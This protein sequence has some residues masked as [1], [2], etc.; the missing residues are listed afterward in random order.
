MIKTMKNIYVKLVNNEYK[1]ITDSDRQELTDCLMFSFLKSLKE[2]PIKE[3]PQDG[4]KVFTSEWISD[5]TI[6]FGTKNY[7]VFIYDVRKDKISLFKDHKDY[8]VKSILEENIKADDINFTGIKSIKRNNYLNFTSYSAHKD[9]YIYKGLMEYNHLYNAHENW[10][11]NLEWTDNKLISSSSDNTL[12]VWGSDNSLRLNLKTENDYVRNFKIKGDNLY[13]MYK[14]GRIKIYNMNKMKFESTV[15]RRI[16]RESV[17]LKIFNNEIIKGYE[18]GVSIYDPRTM[19]RIKK[20]K[21]PYDSYGVRSIE[22]N[23]YNNQIYS[24]GTDKSYLHFYD[25]R[26]G[27]IK[28]MKLK[29]VNYVRDENYNRIELSANV[30]LFDINNTSIFT[31]KY[32]GNQIFCGGGLTIAGLNGSFCSL[33]N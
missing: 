7:K 26:K 19:N 23:P 21:L 17:E 13:L 31:H 24:I 14:N 11:S 5:N 8:C 10:I 27:F 20:L 2:Y 9:I 29:N 25:R 4:N 28:S 12:K 16:D 1:N 3:L 18:H 6:M 15:S 33:I 32:R 22:N 30:N